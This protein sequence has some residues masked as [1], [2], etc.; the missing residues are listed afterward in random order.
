MAARVNR[1][2]REA[3]EYL[4]TQ[5]RGLREVVGKKRILL[6]DDQRLRLTVKGKILGLSRLRELAGIM[7]PSRSDTSF[8]AAVLQHRRTNRIPSARFDT[9]RGALL[10]CRVASLSRASLMSVLLLE[11]QSS[12]TWSNSF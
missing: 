7:T 6:N 10:V 9:N 4:L 12:L 5:N 1:G 2:Q 3:I 8:N 11:F